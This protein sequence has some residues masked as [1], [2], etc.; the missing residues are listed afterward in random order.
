AQGM[1]E[2]EPETKAL[3][4]TYLKANFSSER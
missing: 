4:L 3:I 1:V 2:P